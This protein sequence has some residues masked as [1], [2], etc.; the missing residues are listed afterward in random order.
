MR[1][2]RLIGLLIA[3]LGLW[4]ALALLVGP[5]FGYGFSPDTTWHVT[6]DRVWLS[7][8]PGAAAVIGGVLLFAAHRRQ[9]GLVGGGLALAAGAWFVVGPALSL[10]WHG[11]VQPFVV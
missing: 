3:G 1:S 11:T 4:G 9:I 10:L 8:V 5:Y 6:A 2:I 7:I